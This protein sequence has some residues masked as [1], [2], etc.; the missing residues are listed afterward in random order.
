MEHA[1]DEYQ[2]ATEPEHVD[3]EDRAEE[4]E[5][6]PSRRT[7]EYRDLRG[8]RI[9]TVTAVYGEPCAFTS[10]KGKA[11]TGRELTSLSLTGTVEGEDVAI[12]ILDLTNRQWM[13]IVVPDERLSNYFYNPTVGDT[14]PFAVVPP[15]ETP[16]DMAVLLHELGHSAQY[17]EQRFAPLTPLYGRAVQDVIRK[18]DSLQQT[19]RALTSFSKDADALRKD[20]GLRAVESIGGTML[21]L[22]TERGLKETTPMR[23]TEIDARMEIAA[24]TLGQAVTRAL[25]GS[26]NVAEIAE[27][28]KKIMERDATRR[29]YQ[30]MRAIRRTA[31]ANLFAEHEA[32]AIALT[33]DGQDEGCAQDVAAMLAHDVK[34]TVATDAKKDL[35]AAL[36][37]YRAE[38]PPSKALHAIR[39]DMGRDTDRTASV[40]RIVSGAGDAETRDDEMLTM[41]LDR[42][43]HDAEDAVRAYAGLKPGAPLT[44]FTAFGLEIRARFDKTLKALLATVE[45]KREERKRWESDRD[46]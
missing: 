38:K 26:A 16:L 10:T 22:Q 8:E 20:E 36:A 44:G 17:E 39:R 12:D 11:E 29:A 33:K 13:R 6:V 19:L 41:T 34:R 25:S 9:C 37:S 15:P 40:K 35:T 30:W 31:G 28:P 18:P 23:M 45:E 1:F 43:I 3:A 46:A 27:L 42:E 32:P 4:A 7:Y 2:R 5:A 24:I 14:P 21:D